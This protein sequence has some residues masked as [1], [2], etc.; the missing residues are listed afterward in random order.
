MSDSLTLWDI[1]AGMVEA[2][3]R[4]EDAEAIHRELLDLNAQAKSI[5]DT[6]DEMNAAISQS[7]NEVL[8][9]R[10]ALEAYMS[11]E[12]KKVDNIAGFI[13]VCGKQAELAGAEIERIRARRDAWL[14][15]AERVKQICIHVLKAF[16]T[17]RVESALNR[18]R[19]Q[20]NPASV[21]VFDATLIPSHMVYVTV[22][23]TETQWKHLLSID[24]M[25]L[26]PNMVKD[27]EISL[28]TV[29]DALKSVEVPGARIADETHHLRVE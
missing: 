9:A 27:R 11:A 29:K 16:P 15:R 21:Y 3:T 4:V 6:G 8:D 19:L 23:M 25:S 20:K 10:I 22:R 17:K 13:R 14:A 12:I 28:S 24:P 26:N 5:K 1:Q 18:L 7:A 2:I